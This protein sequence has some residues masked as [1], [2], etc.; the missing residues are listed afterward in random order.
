[1]V[2]GAFRKSEGT[3]L[4]YNVI[5]TREGPLTPDHDQGSAITRASQSTAIRSEDESPGGRRRRSST[6]DTTPTTPVTGSRTNARSRQSGAHT[7]PELL[8]IDPNHGRRKRVK[9][10]SP[11]V[12]QSRM[13][14]R[15]SEATDLDHPAINSR[16]QTASKSNKVLRLN[17]KT[18]TIGSPPAKKTTKVSPSAG[19]KCVSGK[20]L[21]HLKSLV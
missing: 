19:G 1:M 7:S 4:T 14:V 6:K 15:E 11:E 21:K 10:T 13:V 18:G 8:D 2:D 3:M 16:A 12:S 17:P 20:T 9:S 5:G